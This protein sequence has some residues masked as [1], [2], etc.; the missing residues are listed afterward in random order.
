[1]RKIATIAVVAVVSLLGFANAA[2][3]GDTPQGYV[4][5]EG[6]SLSR[7]AVEHNVPEEWW[8]AVAADNHLANP[9]QIDIDQVLNLR[10]FTNAEARWYAWFS[11]DHEG[12]NAAHRPA[13]RPEP[14]IA[15]PVPDTAEQDFEEE[16]DED[17]GPEQENVQGPSNGWAI[18]ESIVMCE[19]GGDYGAENPTSSAS[20]AYQ[21]IDETWDN[22]GGYAHASDAP[23]SVQD[24]RAA[25]IYDG[26]AGRGNWVC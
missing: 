6:D 13:P 1:M 12:Y 26:G 14:R 2:F 18:P 4:V 16:S 21:I 11:F 3:A 9:D 22:Y 23:P 24:E 25:Q 20:G 10:V 19:S 17:E 5:E 7:I 15:T 8:R